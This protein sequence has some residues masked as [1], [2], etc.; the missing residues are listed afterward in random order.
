MNKY[1]Y[2]MVPGEYPWKIQVTEWV[3]GKLVTFRTGKG[4]E[5]LPD[6]IRPEGF[7]VEEFDDYIEDEL[8]DSEGTNNNTA[9]D[10]IVENDDDDEDEDEIEIEITDFKTSDDKE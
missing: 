5:V 2:D 6:V 8:T 1:D 4:V 9:I 3:R 7:G 10:D